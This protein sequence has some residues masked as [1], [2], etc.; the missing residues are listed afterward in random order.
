MA[1]KPQ[2]TTWIRCDAL[3]TLR[4]LATAH[5]PTISQVAADILEHGFQERAE[6]A[7]SASSA[8][9]SRAS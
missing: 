7:G 6:T 4:D 9:R 8:P 1:D 2:V 3:L 5:Q